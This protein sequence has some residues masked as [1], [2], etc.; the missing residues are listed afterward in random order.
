MPTTRHLINAEALALMKPT[1]TLINTSRGG[2]I[3]EAA[4]IQALKE[5]RLSGAALDVLQQEPPA[6]D[7]PLL[8]FDPY[9][10]ILTP[11]AAASS[12]EVL[13]DLHA[14]VATAFSALLA[15]HLPP[16]VMNPT[17]RPKQP[18]LPYRS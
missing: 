17:V 15:G 8:S 6:S 2:V 18:L 7:N 5:N 3:D 4:L 9:R 10:V 1:A 11:H 13:D 12:D 14:E 16:S